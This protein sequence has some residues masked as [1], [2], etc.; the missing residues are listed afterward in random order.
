ML[1]NYIII[2]CKT[3]NNARKYKILLKRKPPRD[4]AVVVGGGE[5]SLLGGVWKGPPR[6]RPSCAV[7][8]SS[9]G[10][11]VATCSHGK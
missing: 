5:L 6:G 8:V 3:D 9:L 1:N 10:G 4:R 7:C 2:H 11:S